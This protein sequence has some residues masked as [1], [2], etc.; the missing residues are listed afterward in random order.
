MNR[1]TRTVKRTSTVR[2]S[3][4]TRKSP[5]KKK[6]TKSNDVKVKKAIKKINVLILGPG[7]PK[8]ELARRI[9]IKNRLKKLDV[10][11][12]V[13]EEEKAVAQQITHV[14]K[15]A[16][17]LKKDNLLCIA[18]ST[19]DGYSLGLTFEIGFICGKFGT[20]ITGKKR[21]GRELGFLIDNDA[22]RGDILS[23]YVT[24]GILVDGTEMQFNYSNMDELIQII[25]TWTKKRAK[26]LGLF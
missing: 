4:Q 12:F 24:S 1:K 13:M 8:K 20:S 5:S 17:L 26:N 25:Y 11:A 6:F 10:N 9:K 16:D 15:F 14:D 21:L 22:N 18:I 2:K 23:S 3:S 19:K 7:Y